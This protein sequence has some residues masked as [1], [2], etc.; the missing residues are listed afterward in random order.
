VRALHEKREPK[1]DLLQS[2]FVWLGW[3]GSG[4][5]NDALYIVLEQSKTDTEGEKD[6]RRKQAACQKTRTGDDE[7]AKIT[8]SGELRDFLCSAINSVANGTM[9]IEKAREI[10][11]LAGQVNESFYA[12]VKVARLQ[13]DLGRESSKLGQLKVNDDDE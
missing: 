1:K 3:K 9:G 12:E 10:T 11:K 2:C 5:K 4:F 7:M 8:K 6:G 13:L